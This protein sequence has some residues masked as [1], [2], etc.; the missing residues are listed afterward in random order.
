MLKSSD[1]VMLNAALILMSKLT[2]REAE[3]MLKD[4]INAATEP[5]EVFCSS[6]GAVRVLLRLEGQRPRDLVHIIIG[7]REVS[8]DVCGESRKEGRASVQ[9]LR[10]AM[11]C[12]LNPKSRK[13]VQFLLYGC[14]VTSPTQAARDVQQLLISISAEAARAIYALLPK[15]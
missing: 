9:E 5:E 1:F 15:N 3:A 7:E 11:Q 6:D 14:R 10:G 4:K 13:D 12:V 2:T 8:A